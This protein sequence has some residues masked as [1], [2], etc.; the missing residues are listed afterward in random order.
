MM[1]PW[2]LA[3]TISRGKFASTAALSA[4]IFAD[5]ATLAM[6]STFGCVHCMLELARLR[7]LVWQVASAWHSAGSAF[8]SVS[9]FGA[10]NVPVHPPRQDA[11]APHEIPLCAVTRHSPVQVPL[12]VPLHLPLHVASVLVP[13]S[14]MH[15]PA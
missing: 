3:A 11:D 15:V 2:A 7:Q 5:A 10:L 6:S 14:A 1:G 9:H 13:V 12:H 4:G 8:S